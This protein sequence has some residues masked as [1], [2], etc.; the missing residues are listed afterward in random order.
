[1]RIEDDPQDQ[2]LSL[3]ITPLIDIIFILVLFFAVTTS[4]INPQEIDE[5][6]VQLLKLN[7][8]KQKLLGEI[9]KYT[10]QVNDQ[11][12]V[13]Q[14]LKDNYN[15]LNFDYSRVLDTAKEQTQQSGTRLQAAEAKAQ[16]LQRRLAMLEQRQSDLQQKL[17]DQT[18]RSHEVQL[19]SQQLATELQTQLEAFFK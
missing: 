3:E 1:M 14:S 10:A 12:R 13:I 16:Q 4:F 15:N 19:Q 8:V 18:A 7:K 11:S 2:R 5:L 17:A 6:K 9:R